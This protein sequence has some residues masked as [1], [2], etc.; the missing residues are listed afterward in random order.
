MSLQSRLIICSTCEYY[1]PLKV[2]KKCK[3]FIPLKARL[4]RTEC[5]LGKWEKIDGYVEKRNGLGKS[6]SL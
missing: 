3:C 6:K 1:T 2:C 5:P 4:K